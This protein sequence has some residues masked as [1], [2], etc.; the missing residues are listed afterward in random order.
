MVKFFKKIYP[1]H[2]ILIERYHIQPVLQEIIKSAHG[3]LIDI[4]CGEKP[5][6]EYIHHKVDRYVGLDHPETPHSKR[7]IDVLSTAYSIPFDHNTFD[8]ALLTQV[9]EHL[10][11][12]KNALLEINR[13]L[14]DDGLLILA[15]PFLYPI[16]EAP[17]DF[18]RYTFYG[19]KFLAGETNFEVQ[20]LVAP[21]GFWIMFF[22][23]FSVYL[24]GKSKWVY[25]CLSPF[26][27]LFFILCML[28]NLIDKNTGSA[29]KWTWNYYAILKKKPKDVKR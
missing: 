23:L 4:G 25:L 6:Y 29:L 11:E 8:I 14:K 5:F 18:F 15:W 10:E 13:I 21:S 7:G 3:N 22:G 16:H 19:M 2:R 12:P 28:I 9:I 20:K 24:Y 1:F 27:C 17:R 26:I